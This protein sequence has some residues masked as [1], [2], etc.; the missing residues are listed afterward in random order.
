MSASTCSHAWIAI[1]WTTT[2]SGLKPNTFLCADCAAIKHVEVNPEEH[3]ARGV[4]ASPMVACLILA[5]VVT[6][7]LDFLR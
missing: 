6:A 2:D 4:A 7:A 3:R 5:G 1:L